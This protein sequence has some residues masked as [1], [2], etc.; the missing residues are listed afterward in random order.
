[1]N[2]NLTL[3][4]QMIAFTIFVWFCMKYVWPPLINAMSERQ[5]KLDA[6]L[7]DAEKAKEGL[8]A[9]KEQAQ[10][11]VNEAKSQAAELIEQANKRAA[12]LIEESKTQAKAEGDRLKS[13]A[14]AEI[15]QEFNRA[16]E[17]LRANVAELA[18]QGAGKI[19]EAEVDR[20]AHAKMLSALSASL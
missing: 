3:F 4:G 18:L 6:G 16:K 9:A 11:I 15:D 5:K 10:S 12:Q 2:I 17:S 7:Q 13:A 20:S 8:A 19:L 1:M 14:Q